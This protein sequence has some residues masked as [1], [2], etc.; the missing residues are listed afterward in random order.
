MKL[1]CVNSCL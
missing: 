1:I